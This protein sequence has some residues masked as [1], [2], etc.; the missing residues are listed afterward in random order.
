LKFT[1]RNLFL[2]V[3]FCGIFYLSLR[4]IVDPDFWWH[5]RTGQLIDQTQEV[6]HAD[7]FSFTVNAKQWVT[8][9]WLSELFIFESFKLGGYG[10]LIFIFSGVITASFLFAYLRC[11]KE[12]KPYVAGFT[13]LLGA[14]TSAPIWGV[15]PQMFTLLFTSIFLF[16][17][18]RYR[19]NGNFRN[20]IP[21]PMITIL[22]VNLHAGYIIGIAIEIIYIFGYLLEVAILRYRRK[23]KI[24]AV[25][26]KSL[27]ILFSV[28]I[29]SV[30]AILLNPAGFRILTYPFQTLTDS[31]MQ[32]YIQEWF[33]PDFH[34]VIWQP[35]AVMIL[36][37]IGVGMIGNRPI[38]I[39]KILLTL[40]FGY[41]A[42]RSMRNIPLFAIVV[43][44]VLA[45]QF[46]YLIEFKLNAQKQN[47]HFRYIAPIVI[48]AIAVVVV[49]GF[50]QVTNNQQKS[51]AETFPKDAVDWI[52]ENKPKGN[53]FN[54]YNWGGYIIWRLYPEYLVYIDGR[55]D[56]YGEEFV[57]NYTGIYFTKPGWEEK[58]N[59]ENI[60]I[61][62][63]ES[64]SMLADAVRQSSTWKKLFEDNISVIFLKK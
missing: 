24:D 13:L 8:H 14:I 62:F 61:V 54:S 19:R 50:I 9:E 63:V 64:D 27:W 45:E 37:L 15:R 18:D 26:Q 12:S 16:L 20:L 40:V 46:N 5:L 34:Q 6:P 22:W 23:E 58:L 59:Q 42:L 32:R 53:I 10:L 52:I 55:A 2:I 7:P 31:A 17:L 36:V 47:R 60:R 28:L 29:T 3:L 51:E 4:P 21:I 57:S 43:I 25:T 48:S 1:I 35:F 38:S 11:S 33:S 41:G 44:P 56:L 30:L 39:T 49:L